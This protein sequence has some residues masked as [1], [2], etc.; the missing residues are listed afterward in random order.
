MLIIII[1]NYSSLINNVALLFLILL[2]F[3]VI[4]RRAIKF[5]APLKYESYSSNWTKFE[6]NFLS[7]FQFSPNCSIFFKTS[8]TGEF[9]GDRNSVVQMIK[10]E[11]GVNGKVV[12]GGGDNDNYR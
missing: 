6:F 5:F 12:V 2:F 1:I 7:L 10:L 4:T 9:V 8:P 3:F 11:V